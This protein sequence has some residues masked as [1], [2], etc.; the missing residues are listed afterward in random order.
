MEFH[1][2]EASHPG[3]KLT[4]VL[5]C[6]FV[7]MGCNSGDQTATMLLERGRLYASG[8]KFTEAIE[9]F[10]QALQNSP[11][12]SEIYYER[13]LAWERSG[14]AEEAVADYEQAIQLQPTFSQAHN[15]LASICARHKRYPEA[16]EGFS[17]ALQFNPQD[18]LAFRNRGLVHHD[19]G[20][21]KEALADFQHS[22]KLEP[23][24]AEPLF[25][26][27][28]TYLEMN[29]LEHAM[30]SFNAAVRVNPMHFASFRN[31]AAVHRK[32]GG[33]AA[34]E[35]DEQRA[36]ELAPPE[37]LAA[38]APVAAPSIK[39]LKITESSEKLDKISF[40]VATANSSDSDDNSPPVPE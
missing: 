35:Q 32:L 2:S 28:N 22:A 19:M 37:A 34:A 39:E 27:G 14:H 16:L 25:L 9:S 40:P 5:V 23:T 7:A 13:A 36:K 18:S 17:R 3:F 6:C 20:N 1:M 4:F 11:N 33:I 31:R 29:D 15:N 38:P 10:T 8:D 24:S 12:N 21:Y 30:I 26:Q